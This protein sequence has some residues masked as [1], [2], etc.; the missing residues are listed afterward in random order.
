MDFT[1][2]QMILTLKLISTAVSFQDGMK[3]DKARP[4]VTARAQGPGGS[5]W[6]GPC[7]LQRSRR[8]SAHVL[9][10]GSRVQ[11]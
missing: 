9:A 8:A 3:P 5:P 6:S 2:A 1:G 10:S 4:A 11:G 7:S